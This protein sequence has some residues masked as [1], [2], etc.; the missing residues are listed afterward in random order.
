MPP[1]A[2][3]SL[4]KA[5]D[6]VANVRAPDALDKLASAHLDEEAR[7]DRQSTRTLREGAVPKVV[8]IG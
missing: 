4:K 2:R 5:V 7:A 1:K 6:E 3:V 8:G